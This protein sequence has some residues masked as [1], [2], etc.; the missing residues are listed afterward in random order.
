[1]ESNIPENSESPEEHFLTI[2][3]V[4]FKDIMKK[5][6]VSDVRNFITLNAHLFRFFATHLPDDLK[7][8]WEDAELDEESQKRLEAQY[9]AF[10]SRVDAFI[11][12]LD[13]EIQQNLTDAVTRGN[14]NETSVILEVALNSEQSTK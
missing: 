9:E 14:V 1:M 11:A 7:E 4:V 6:G 10:H 5:E 2:Q 3:A 8:S 13:P 12:N